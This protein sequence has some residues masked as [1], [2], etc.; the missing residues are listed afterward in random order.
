MEQFQVQQQNIDVGPA[1]PV[2]SYS[3]H[4]TRPLW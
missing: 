4:Q 3:L 2:A 1:H